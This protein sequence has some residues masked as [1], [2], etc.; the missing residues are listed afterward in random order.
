MARSW[1]LDGTDG[2]VV[3][4]LYGRMAM[5]IFTTKIDLRRRPGIATASPMW[6]FGCPAFSSPILRFGDWLL[7]W[8]VHDFTLCGQCSDYVHFM[9]INV[10]LFPFFLLC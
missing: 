9:M 10:V 4:T 6:D 2:E 1:L 7:V 5:L 3:T 8:C